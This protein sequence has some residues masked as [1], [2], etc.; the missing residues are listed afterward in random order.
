LTRDV[1]SLCSLVLLV[2]FFSGHGFHSPE[3]G[4]DFLLPR[5][6]VS[7]DLEYT[8]IEFSKILE[9]LRKWPASKILLFTDACRA[10]SAGGKNIVI[11]N[12]SPVNVRNLSAPGMVCFASCVPGQRSYEDEK[13]Q[14]GIFTH[15]LTNGLS[16][17]GRC[18]TVYELDCFLKKEMPVISKARGKPLQNPFTR[19]EPLEMQN[20]VLI[21]PDRLL[22]W[23]SQFPAGIEVRSK[24][25]LPR[26][27]TTTALVKRSQN[28]C[29]LDFGTS[30]STIGIH[31]A[32]AATSLIPSAEGK[33][34]VPSVVSFAANL[35][36][37]VGWAALEKAR[38]APEATIFHIKRHL[39]SDKVFNIS[40]KSF[41]PEMLAALIIS[42]LKRNAEEYLGHSVAEVLISAPANF[43]IAQ[44]NALIRACEIAQLKV[45]RIIGEPCAASLVVQ[46]LFKLTNIRDGNVIVLDLGGGTFDIAV[47]EF[48]DGVAEIK[49][50]VGDNCLGGI[51][52]DEALFQFSLQRFLQDSR[53]GATFE[54][55]QSDLSRLRYECERAKIALGS[56]HETA[57]I[58]QNIE[59]LGRGMIDLDLPISR[60]DFREATAPLNRRVSKLI[61]LALKRSGCSPLDLCSVILAGQGCKVFTITEMLEQLFV[62]VPIVTRFQECAVGYGL[63]KYTGV[64]SGFEKDL[65]LLDANYTTLELRCHS[66]LTSKRHESPDA[67]VSGDVSLNSKHL[68]LLEAGTTIPTRTSCLL[69]VKDPVA[70]GVTLTVVERGNTGDDKVWPVA[71]LRI[72]AEKGDIL[73]LLVDC[74]ASRTLLL[75]CKVPSKRKLHTFQLNNPYYRRIATHIDAADWRAER[76]FKTEG[77]AIMPLVRV[78]DM[79]G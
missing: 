23:E 39:G 49:A 74:D 47:L 32:D 45:R 26:E 28:M 3:S 11:E 38:I 12:W 18:K 69:K 68:L 13:L 50:V 24:Q 52:F 5:D 54:L 67:S 58:L 36:Y 48:G 64:L 44:S 10:S 31:A 19:V 20:L 53:L 79:K 73:E 46:E 77:Y 4:K 56:R 63:C 65:L 25:I 43:T 21:S 9:Y 29:G 1:A 55:A 30:Y 8:S 33:T 70:G 62:T 71:E 72:D 61:E 51:D 27:A 76:R 42:H 59:V 17:M 66:L 41:R 57:I 15:C 37:C 34:L 75:H 14:N 78:F 6:A 22:Q 35:D 40:G 60:A 16:D 7:T 2:F